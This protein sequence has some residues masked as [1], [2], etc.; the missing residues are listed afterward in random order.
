LEKYFAVYDQH[1][2]A[3]MLMRGLNRD[4]AHISHHSWGDI[5]INNKKRYQILKM[6]SFDKKL[7]LILQFE[8]NDAMLLLL[9]SAI[10]SDL[11]DE[12]LVWRKN[13][14]N[15]PLSKKD[16]KSG[17]R[18]LP[19]LLTFINT[20]PKAHQEKN[21][22]FLAAVL[23]ELN[24]TIKKLPS[25]LDRILFV[26]GRRNVTLSSI[27]REQIIACLKSLGFARE[28]KRDTKAVIK[29]AQRGIP[30]E[31]ILDQLSLPPELAMAKQ[32]NRTAVE[33][34]WDRSGLLSA[35]RKQSAQ[36]GHGNRF[37][38]NSASAQQKAM[39][40]ANAAAKHASATWIQNLPK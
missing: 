39:R 31:T 10:L 26:L 15:S 11:A 37:Y 40:E 25:A 16:L 20:L 21:K 12:Q 18:H 9:K 32:S 2:P 6:M 7:R 30:A 24:V 17:L 35:H 3:L 5:D 29:R 36:L 23:L 22:Q 1:E 8:R 19:A 4:T 27:C 34:V 13:A 28:D 33:Y 38:F 14:W